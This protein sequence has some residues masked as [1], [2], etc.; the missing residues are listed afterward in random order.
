MRVNYFIGQK[1]IRNDKLTVYVQK[2][3]DII[4]KYI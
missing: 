3:E 1:F 2:L 4:Y